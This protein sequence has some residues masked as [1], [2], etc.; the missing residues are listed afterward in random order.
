VK[1]PEPRYIDVVE[2][3]LEDAFIEYTRGRKRSI[4]LFPVEASDVE[5]AVAQGVA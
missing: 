5:S 1:E 3:N 4:P 2:L